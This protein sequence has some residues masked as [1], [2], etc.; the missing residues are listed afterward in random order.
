MLP[1]RSISIISVQAPTKLNTRHLYRLDATDNLPSGIIPLA[2][3]HKLI[4]SIPNY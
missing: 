4:T 2:V 3:D 1:P